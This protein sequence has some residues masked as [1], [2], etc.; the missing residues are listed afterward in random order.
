MNQNTQ[1]G[2]AYI[3]GA[4]VAM[5]AFYALGFFVTKHFAFPF[6]E[7]TAPDTQIHY[8]MGFNIV[9][10]LVLRAIGTVVVWIVGK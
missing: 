9:F 6:A 2:L 8:L 5:V 3:F 4:I 10:T 1:K 7:I